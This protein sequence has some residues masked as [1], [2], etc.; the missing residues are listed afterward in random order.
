MNE[1]LSTQPGRSHSQTRFRQELIRQ[2]RDAP[3][4][5]KKAVA[6]LTERQ[7]R[8]TCRPGGRTIA[9]VVHHMAEM[10]TGAY[11][12]LKFALTEDIPTVGAASQA[13]WAELA[14]A[15]STSP[16]LAAIRMARV[17]SL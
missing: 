15:K 12:R 4:H 14:D 17:P 10:D 8:S 11:T 1:D 9:Q 16:A 3:G 2:C 13:L 7:L 6:D 5:L